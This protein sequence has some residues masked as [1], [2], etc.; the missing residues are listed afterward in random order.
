[1]DARHFPL[2]RTRP[3]HPLTAASESATIRVPTAGEV[4][5]WLIRPVSKTGRPE[6]VSWV[7]IPPSPP[8]SYSSS[9][10]PWVHPTTEGRPTAV[11]NAVR[12]TAVNPTLS[13]NLVLGSEAPWFTRPPKNR[14]EGTP[15]QDG[16]KSHPLRQTFER[17]ISVCAACS[18]LP[19]SPFPLPRFSSRR[20]LL[21]DPHRLVLGRKMCHRPRR[22]RAHRTD[23]TG[24]HA[25]VPPEGR[26]DGLHRREGEDRPPG[27]QPQDRR[28]SARAT[29]C[30][31]KPLP[32]DAKTLHVTSVKVLEKYA[33][34][35]SVD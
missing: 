29:T 28:G 15:S 31:S 34:K 13:A 35:C 4:L 2:G 6:R 20:L 9:E 7:Q 30:R 12:R 11:G 8:I 33:A 19:R 25:G 24:L 26:P 27:R 16:G 18:P 14:Q 22:R 32:R 17:K 21:H 23:G 10:A 5:E 3:R 1:M